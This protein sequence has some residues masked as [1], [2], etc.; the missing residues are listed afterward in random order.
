M[1]DGISMDD[2][3]HRKALVFSEKEQKR[4]TFIVIALTII[5]LI[6]SAYGHHWQLGW[7]L[8]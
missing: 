2:I 3:I 5:I 4:F 6:V 1:T 7:P 8:S